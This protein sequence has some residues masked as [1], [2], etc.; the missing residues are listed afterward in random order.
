MRT[1]FWQRDCSFDLEFIELGFGTAPLGIPCREISD[2]EAERILDC[3]RE[4]G[5]VAD[6]AS[7]WKIAFREIPSAY[8]HVQ[9]SNGLSRESRRLRIESSLDR[10]PFSPICRQQPNP[11]PDNQ[12]QLKTRRI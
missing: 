5:V 10:R 12:A 3:V 11:L 7:V 2:D 9:L 1:N 6:V 8:W 4:S